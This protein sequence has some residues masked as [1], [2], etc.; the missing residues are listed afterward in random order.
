M[1]RTHVLIHWLY[2]RLVVHDFKSLLYFRK[3]FVNNGW[4]NALK[5]SGFSLVN[6]WHL[7]A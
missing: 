4:Y 3:I 5:A 7:T 1:K 2:N 6:G